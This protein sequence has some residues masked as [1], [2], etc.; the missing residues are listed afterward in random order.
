MFKKII[1]SIMLT[2]TLF[3]ATTAN[4]DF[5]HREHFWG[6]HHGWYRGGVGGWWGGFPILAGVVIGG[7]VMHEIDVNAQPYGPYS[8]YIRTVV[9]NPWTYVDQWGRLINEQQCHVEWIPPV[10][11]YSP[12]LTMPPQQ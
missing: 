11:N 1:L 3:T 6:G 2:A 4:A 7:V 10:N 8:G 12:T 5:F 9:C